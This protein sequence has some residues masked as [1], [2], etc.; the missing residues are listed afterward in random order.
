MRHR[1]PHLVPRLAAVLLLLFLATGPALPQP[2]T[3]G[4]LAAAE[5]AATT[6]LN[7]YFQGDVERAVALLHPTVLAESKR[8][9]ISLLEQAE[10]EDDLEPLRE[11]LGVEGEI[12]E[13]AAMDAT[14]LVVRLVRAE[15]ARI[16]E[17]GRLEMREAVVEATGSEPLGPDTARVGLRVLTPSPQGF[18]AQDT[19]VDLRRYQ[20][21][22]RILQDSAD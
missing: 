4:D 15:R 21:S 18:V 8:D 9:L 12:E 16:P 2:A 22:W 14:D 13:L 3:P 5:T 10:A 1:L 7:A 20:G 17:A 6:Y 19:A 11:R